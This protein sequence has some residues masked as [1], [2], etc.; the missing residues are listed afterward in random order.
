MKVLVLGAAGM[1]G[2]KMAEVLEVAGH[3]VVGTGHRGEP[4]LR[5]LEAEDVMGLTVLAAQEKPDVVVNCI[6]IV[7]KNASDYWVNAEFPHRVAEVCR[8]VGAKMIHI[9]TDCVFRG[10]TGNYNENVYPDAIEPYGRS[11]LFGE[12]K[13]PHLTI[14]T[15]IVGRSANGRGL[16]EWFLAQKGPVT[17]YAKAIFSGLTTLELS[18]IVERTISLHPDLSGIWHVSSDPIS[19][20][21]LLGL[22]GWAYGHDVQIQADAA[23][24]VDRSLDSSKF[25]NETGWKPWPWEHMIAEMA[26]DEP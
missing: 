15:S 17:G 24:E 1:L 7:D 19:K 5:H 14:R 11:K 23:F 25:R 9:S 6:G 18:R 13:A 8:R 22:F 16:L 12:V 10:T 4:M 20:Y 3:D 21:D 26:T 2:H